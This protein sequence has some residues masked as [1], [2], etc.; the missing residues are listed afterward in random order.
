M[1]NNF[2]S[3][4]CSLHNDGDVIK[5]FLLRLQASL[6]NHFKHFEIICVDDCSVDNTSEKLR[7]FKLESNVEAITLIHLSHK[8]GLERALQAGLDLAIGDFVIEFES[9][10]MDYPLTTI[11]R[12]YQ[13]ALSGFDIVGVGPKE[14]ESL[15]SK[16]FYS[17]FNRVS[18]IPNILRTERFRIISRRGINRMNSMYDVFPYRKAIFANIGLPSKFMPYEKNAHNNTTAVQNSTKD[19][20]SLAIDSFILYSNIA[21]KFSIAIAAIMMLA[22]VATGIYTVAIMCLGLPVTQGWATMMCFISGVAFMLSFMFVM[23]FKYLSILMTITMNKVN[24][25]VFSIEKL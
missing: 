4:V 19:R 22:C 13:T 6:V 7:E 23:V 24:Y 17:L 14:I 8:Q 10:E 3:V 2:L 5:E 11:Y 18:S 16:A 1:E 12:A 20:I 15:G 21:F 25:T 9:L